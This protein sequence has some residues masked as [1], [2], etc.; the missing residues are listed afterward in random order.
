MPMLL[1]IT[2]LSSIHLMLPLNWAIGDQPFIPV[3]EL[4]LSFLKD[5]Q[6]LTPVK[7]SIHDGHGVV[8]T[9]FLLQRT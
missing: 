6:I 4:S 2:S 3:G 9:G 7:A 8:I 5:D 1:E